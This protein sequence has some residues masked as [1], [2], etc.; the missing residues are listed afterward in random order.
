MCNQSPTV[1]PSGERNFCCFCQARSLHADSYND[2]Q[3][4]SIQILSL[5]F[6]DL[7]RAGELRYEEQEEQQSEKGRCNGKRKASGSGTV[8]QSPSPSSEHGVE[9]DQKALAAALPFLGIAHYGSGRGGSVKNEH[10]R[11]MSSLSSSFTPSYRAANSDH[12]RRTGRWTAAETAYVDYIVE[13]FEAG[14]LPLPQGV[15]LNEFL[16]DALMCKP[17]RLTKKMKSAKLSM[18]SFA[19]GNWAVD[20]GSDVAKWT[21]LSK[22]EG[23]FLDSIN[24][25]Y[26]RLEAQFN[27]QRMWRT[28]FWNL[29]LQIGFASLDIATEWLP[30][31]ETMELR[32]GQ[33]EEEVRRAERRKMGM[34]LKQDAKSCCGLS[35]VFIGGMPGADGAIAQSRGLIMDSPLTEADP[36]LAVS[37][38][39]DNT[40]STWSHFGALG[41]PRSVSRSRSGSIA[42]PSFPNAPPSNLNAGGR[43]STAEPSS[44][45]NLSAS[46][47]TQAELDF[48]NEIFSAEGTGFA[49]PFDGNARLDATKSSVITEANVLSAKDGSSNGM[50]SMVSMESIQQSQ[51]DDSS[52]N[53]SFVSQSISTSSGGVYLDTVVKFLS[54]MKAPFQTAEC[55]VPSFLPS[56]AYDGTDACEAASGDGEVA[57]ATAH[58]QDI[59]HLRLCYAGRAILSDAVSSSTLKNMAAYGE[60]SSHFSFSPGKGE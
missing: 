30:S 32:A 57:R 12:R 1:S 24:P 2:I 44:N 14:I 60:Y 34:A 54:D 39:I 37:S 53:S 56:D 48:L 18:R 49:D 26:L 19:F 38:T 46:T 35:G 42:A 45:R 9:K 17:S 55:W 25:Q 7:E 15:K 27:L 29:C 50:P 52:S 11:T 36:S 51:A 4:E 6:D 33:A 10:L 28:H 3:I 16:S 5:S 23:E 47:T 22:L 59:Q 21:A 8:F 40:K 20:N 13:C 58:P 41:R 43:Q 31:L